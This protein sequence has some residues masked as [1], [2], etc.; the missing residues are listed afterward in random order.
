M[1]EPDMQKT[2]NMGAP[3]GMDLARDVAHQDVQTVFDDVIIGPPFEARL[4]VERLERLLLEQRL[5]LIQEAPEF[6]RDYERWILSASYYG[7]PFFKDAMAQELIRTH[8]IDILRTG[9][10]LREQLRLFLARHISLEDR[11]EL[12]LRLIEAMETST[13]LLGGRV[14]GIAAGERARAGTL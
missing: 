1:A 4:F 14:L 6:L 13:E 10:D 12:R 7:L 9:V 5:R 8:A 2:N 3:A 11:N